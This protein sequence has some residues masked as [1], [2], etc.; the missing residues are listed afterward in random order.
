[1]CLYKYMRR[2]E[3]ATNDETIYNIADQAYCLKHEP[4]FLHFVRTLTYFTF[5]ISTGLGKVTVIKN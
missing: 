3:T 2:R 1:M 4:E 5:K